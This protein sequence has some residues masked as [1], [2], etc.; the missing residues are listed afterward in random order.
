MKNVTVRNLY[1]WEELWSQET[2]DVIAYIYAES[3]LV[4][5][6]NDNF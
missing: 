2:I 6:G 4:V 5:D 1:Y 3:Y